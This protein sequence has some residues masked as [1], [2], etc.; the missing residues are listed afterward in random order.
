[1]ASNLV[2]LRDLAREGAGSARDVR[3]PAGA[4][5]LGHWPVQ[6]ASPDKAGL[7]V[8]QFAQPVMGE[9]KCQ[10]G[11]AF[12]RIAAGHLAEQPVG[13]QLFDRRNRFV[14]GATARVAQR[15]EVDRAP[16][17]GRSGEDLSTRLAH[18]GDSRAQQGADAAR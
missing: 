10:A 14:L 15:V 18:R 17:R 1:M 7:L 12:P 16:D 9:L 3:A 5:R 4:Q 6:Q 13:E 2:V 8:Y 11:C